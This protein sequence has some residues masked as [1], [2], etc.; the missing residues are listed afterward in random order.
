MVT[1]SLSM[2]MSSLH[3]QLFVHYLMS[4]TY[5]SPFCS[6]GYFAEQ[7]EAL[8]VDIIHVLVAS[9]AACYGLKLLL[10]QGLAALFL[11]FIFVQFQVLHICC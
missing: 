8:L 9:S 5:I 11:C 4:F 7:K 3:R 1:Y 6:G 2:A 10:N